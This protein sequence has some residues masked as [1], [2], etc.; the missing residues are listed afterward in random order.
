MNGWSATVQIILAN[1]ARPF[2]QLILLAIFLFFFGLPIIETFSK[3]EVMTVEK[4][5][6]TFGIPSPAITVAAWTQDNQT[7][8]CYA[9]DG[10]IEKC[11]GEK[12]LNRLDLLQGAFIGFETGRDI[13]LTK[14]MFAEDSTHSWSGRYYTLNLPFKLG[15]NDA[16]D[17]LYLFLGN[18]TL[19]TT[20]FIHDPKFFIYTDNPDALP[21]EIISFKTRT[22]FSHFYRLDLVEMHELNVPSDPCNPNSDYNFRDCVK[23]SVSEQVLPLKYTLCLFYI[24]CLKLKSSS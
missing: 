6:N 7:D 2:F 21:M 8:V 13:N 23:K 12:S 20:L 11:I 10:D 1:G 16:T 19:F 22:S 9:L 14:N 3:K 24:V 18:T 17:Q 5:R 15:P 4:R